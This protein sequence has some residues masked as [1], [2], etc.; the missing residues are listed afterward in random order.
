MKKNTGKEAPGIGILGGGLA[1][2]ALQHFLRVPSEVLEKE[3]RPG[4]LCRSWEADGVVCDRGPHIMFSRD[5]ETL[6][7][8]VD[9]LGVNVEKHFRRNSIFYRGRFVKYPFENDIHALEPEDRYRCLKEFLFNPEAGREVR[10]LEDWSYRM[11]GPALAEAYFLPYNEKIWKHPARELGTEWVERIPRIEADDMI[12][13]AVGVS[14]EGYTHQLHF[15]HPREGGI[16]ALVR[17]LMRNRPR[18]ITGAEVT[19]L[20]RNNGI[21]KVKTFKGEREYPEVVCCL[22]VNEMLGFLKPAPP[23]EILEAAGRLKVN[24]LVLVL[25]TYPRAEPADRLAVYIPDPE[26][27]PHRVSWVNYLGGRLVP[28]NLHAA[29]AEITLPGGADSEAPDVNAIAKKTTEQL[30]RLDLIPSGV[31]VKTRAIWEPYGY[32]VNTHGYSRDR[33]LILEY[34]RETGIETLGRWGEFAYLNMDAVWKKARLLAERMNK[35][36]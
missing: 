5:G 26:I 8:M 33:E 28:P 15:Y 31:P 3:D 12:K 19:G 17:A 32:V 23:P 1:G 34:C 36:R 30:R 25:I 20:E 22:P 24:G 21:W 2:V 6:K 11:F 13:S 16:E 27:L 9:I 14:T 35:D 4:G 18:L 10:N 7:E 29:M